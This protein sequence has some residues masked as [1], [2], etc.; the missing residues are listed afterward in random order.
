MTHDGTI[1]YLGSKGKGKGRSSTGKGLGRRKNPRGRDGTIV[2]CRV[3]GSDDHFQA[4]CPQKGS[5]QGSS[6]GPGGPPT[7]HT[8]V[9][10]HQ[11]ESSGTWANAAW[12]GLVAG[13]EEPEGPLTRML[14]E[15]EN[16]GTS[17]QAFVAHTEDDHRI[18]PARAPAGP[19]QVVHEDPWARGY[20]PAA[21]VAQRHRRV[22]SQ[23]AGPTWR[24]APSASSWGSW[25]RVSTPTLNVS[26]SSDETTRLTPEL[27]TR[28]EDI[29]A[30]DNYTTSSRETPTPPPV[31]EAPLPQRP[32]NPTT[33]YSA[34]P[35][36]S[37]PRPPPTRLHLP[38]P[39][40][41]PPAQAMPP[42]TASGS[43]NPMGELIAAMA[44]RQQAST[45]QNPTAAV[46]R[47]NPNPRRDRPELPTVRAVEATRPREPSDL[48]NRFTPSDG[49]L[50][51][52]G[53]EMDPTH[54]L[55][56]E[57]AYHLPTVYSG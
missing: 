5:G 27:P 35:R 19:D 7:F 46:T 32:W 42:V 41:Q 47:P 16:F 34:R 31:L 13:N 6:S 1:A 50:P 21:P 23:S 18:V 10:G 56:P 22:R 3:C 26:G 54:L 55:D 49:H 38:I 20:A 30:W 25:E 53:R 37:Q 24:R 14:A 57:G 17:E 43:G 11:S 9:E 29:G 40:S 44:A 52:Y 2:T 45:P 48:R 39:E 12:H 15:V 51:H 28:A 33:T 4:R 36:T 8:T